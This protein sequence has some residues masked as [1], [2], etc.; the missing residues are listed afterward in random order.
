MNPENENELVLMFTV[1]FASGLWVLDP[2]DDH[3]PKGRA[4]AIM[5]HAEAL[6][7][8]FMARRGIKP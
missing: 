8:E 5:D 7:A 4:V 2:D 3:D 1:A 6:A